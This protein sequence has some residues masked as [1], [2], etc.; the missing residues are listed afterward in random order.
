[1]SQLSATLIG[2]LVSTLATVL[3]LTFRDEH[4]IPLSSFLIGVGA[5]LFVGIVLGFVGERRKRRQ[6]RADYREQQL[7]SDGEKLRALES[8]IFDTHRALRR[9]LR[10]GANLVEAFNETSKLFDKLRSLA[11]D[12]PDLEPY[13]YDLT[14]SVVEWEHFLG[15]LY[16]LARVGDIAR[17]Q[18]LGRFT[19]RHGLWYWLRERWRNQRRR[20]GGR[21]RILRRLRSTL[22]RS[23]QGSTRQRGRRS[24]GARRD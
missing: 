6:D 18:R 3:V 4:H 14:V 10:P 22:K 2:A 19:W 13:D 8:E 21:N 16:P 20:F 1:M 15:H 9:S 17:A 12:G 23:K 11:I 7:R 24:G 5:G